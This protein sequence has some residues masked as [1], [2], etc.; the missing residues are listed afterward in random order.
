[1]L[2]M[3]QMFSSLH[4]DQTRQVREELDHLHAITRELHTLRAE[5]TT[6]AAARPRPR[7]RC[8]PPRLRICPGFPDAR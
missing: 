7:P 2:M 8:P 6:S 4:Q 1:M 3:V 5:L